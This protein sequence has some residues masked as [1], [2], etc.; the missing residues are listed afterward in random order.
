MSL[1]Y[2][3]S[4]SFYL[5]LSIIKKNKKFDLAL[6]VIALELKILYWESAIIQEGV[7]VLVMFLHICDYRR[8][9]RIE[10]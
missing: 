8:R 1:I 4:Y 3:F 9:T 5:I 6:S 10:T 2:C 7:C